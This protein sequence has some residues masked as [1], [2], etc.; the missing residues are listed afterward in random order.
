MG[1]SSVVPRHPYSALATS[2]WLLC[3]NS[4]CKGVLF[5][6]K[7]GSLF[8]RTR[9]PLVFR[10]QYTLHKYNIRKCEDVDYVI[11]QA[12]NF[13]VGRFRRSQEH[14]KQAADATVDPSRAMFLTPSIL[15]YPYTRASNCIK[16]GIIRAKTRSIVFSFDHGSLDVQYFFYCS[17]ILWQ[18]WTPDSVSSCAV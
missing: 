4:V 10:L 8:P 13:S 18:S 14:A 1:R 6:M 15:W 5:R 9:G 11:F 2:W 7:A 12:K 17:P 3:E 16:I